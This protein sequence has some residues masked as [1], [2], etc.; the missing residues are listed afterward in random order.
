MP[1]T[2][3]HADQLPEL[4][5]I[6]GGEFLMGSADGDA[7]E[8]P[9]HLVHV[10]EFMIASRPVTNAEYAAFVQDASYRLPAIH[11]LPLVVTA[12]GRERESV[13]RATSQPYTWTNGQP[14]DGRAQHPVTLVRWDDAV[15]YCSW[16]S[17]TTG[18]TIRLPTEAE[19]EK[20]AR[21]GVAGRRY[22]WGDRIDPELVNFLTDP[23]RKA[24]HG[25]SRCG[26]YPPNDFGLYDMAGNVWEW[27]QDWYAD[28]YYSHA[29]SDNPA[30]PST[31]VMRVLRGGSWLSADVRM[32][33]CAYR[34]KVPP[35][36]YSYA[37]G[38]RVVCEVR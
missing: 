10:D 11:D 17:A 12:G 2:F 25:T 8:R 13:F 16:L 1:S 29:P 30:G 19:W 26:T 18:R 32:L 33:T 4:V 37:I 38:F 22:P 36:T 9:P 23:A 35:D 15:A 27:V 21:G 31:G 3:P 28:D 34:H 20:A 6:P 24:A 14:P 5:I 7:D